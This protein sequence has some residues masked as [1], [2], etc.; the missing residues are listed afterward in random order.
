MAVSA[1]RIL[2]VAL[3]AAGVCPAAASAQWPMLDP[4]ELTL[5]TPRIDPGADAEALLWEVRI[6]DDATLNEPATNLE[7]YVRIKIFNDRGRDAQGKVDL[8][9]TNG[10][11][12]RDIKGRTV[13]PNGT[14]TE[15]N[16]DD[17][18]DRTILEASGLKIKA[19]SFVLPAVVPGAIIE[20]RWREIRDN[21]LAHYLELP[22]Q[23][24]VPIHLVRYYV[25]PLPLRGIGYQMR[26][27]VQNLDTQ[28]ETLKGENGYTIFQVRNMPA[29]GTESLMPAEPSVRAWMLIYYADLAWTNLTEA[30]FW[31]KWAN[32][33][34]DDYEGELRTSNEI[35]QAATEVTRGATSVEQK[36]DALVKFTRGRVKRTDVDTAAASPGEGKPSTGARE[37]L[38]RG[39]GTGD[40]VTVL[41]AALARAAGLE[42]RM[43]VLSDRKDFVA[44]PVS[45]QPVLSVSSHRRREE[46]R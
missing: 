39:A 3:L 46:R 4:A 20:Y 36:I 30:R 18:R 45:R 23:R 13:A 14:I 26:W 35:K 37:T 21:S 34:Y 28:P 44:P 19:K 33:A 7:H 22:L 15:L 38:R 31:D 25:K 42:T 40:D 9:Y 1:L 32:E 10:H 41:F 27:Q 12:I 8:P 11:R 43:A 6:S 2:I 29:V 5:R 16:S 24:E 17:V